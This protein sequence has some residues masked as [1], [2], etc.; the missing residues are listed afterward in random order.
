[1]AVSLSNLASTNLTAVYQAC[2]HDC[3]DCPKLSARGGALRY[4]SESR[5]I[6]KN[7]GP[8]CHGYQLL[9]RVSDHGAAMPVDPASP[10]TL[11]ILMVLGSDFDRPK[12]VD[13][14]KTYEKA[15]LFE[16]NPEVELLLGKNLPG[17]LGNSF[18]DR[19]NFFYK[20]TVGYV[21]IE[22]LKSIPFFNSLR[23]SYF[24]SS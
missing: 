1:M 18:Y 3:Q 20:L 8:Q 17:I 21:C 2:P 24:I 16:M 19:R 13:Q 12:K 6:H 11:H 15:I 14:G 5:N 7:C 4:H 23:F 22:G 9:P 10:P